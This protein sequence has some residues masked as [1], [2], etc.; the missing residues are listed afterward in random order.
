MSQEKPRVLIIAEYIAPV[1]A[2][3]S[4]RWSKFAKYLAKEHGCEVTVLTNRKSYRKGVFQS[5]PYSMDPALEKDLSWFSTVEIPYSLGQAL[6]NAIFN[7]GRNILDVLKSSSTVGAQDD[8]RIASAKNDV[9]LGQKDNR[10]DASLTNSLPEK[11]YELVDGWCGSS[12]A[13]AGRRAAIDWGSYDI[14]VSTFGPLWTHQIAARVKKAYKNV[15]WVADFRDPIVASGRT[16]TEENRK[17][18]DAVTAQADLITAVSEGTFKNLYLPEGRPTA[19]LSNGFDAEELPSMRRTASKRFR[20]VYT[21]TL[22]SDDSRVQDL[23]PLFE[24]LEIASSAGQINLKNV[25][26][27]YAG[28]A[29]YLFKQFSRKHPS[30][31]TVDHGLVPRDEAL[32]MQNEASALVVASWNNSQQTG[33]LT[34]KVF[35]YLGREAPI[36]GLCSGNLPNSDL[37]VLIEECAAGFCYEE[38]QSNSLH[39][40]VDYIVDLYRQWEEC[41]LTRRFPDSHDRAKQYSYSALTNKLVATIRDGGGFT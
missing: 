31:P 3:A 2:V 7:V 12:L 27:D 38:A 29:S 17:A 23:N 36:V 6:S 19:V 22:Y 20:F 37:K 25:C 33:V 34:G 40:L 41:G 14:M 15:F 32:N 18:A 30:V 10:L 28:T 24:A 39:G 9:S 21:G 11:I 8:S 1:Q 5:K 35:E 16:N 4:I 13:R 26:V